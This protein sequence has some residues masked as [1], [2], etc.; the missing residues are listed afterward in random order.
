MF[1]VPLLPWFCGE[2]GYGFVR[3]VYAVGGLMFN[4]SSLI[5]LVWLIVT[6]FLKQN[7]ALAFSAVALFCAVSHTSWL[8]TKYQ[9]LAAYGIATLFY[10]G[11]CVSCG[12]Q[13]HRWRALLH[14]IFACSVYMYFERKQYAGFLLVAFLCAGVLTCSRAMRAVDR[15]LEGFGVW[16]ILFA[17]SVLDPNMHFGEVV[18][19]DKGALNACR[20]VLALNTWCVCIGVCIMLCVKRL[21]GLLEPEDVCGG[22]MLWAASCLS[23]GAFMA[24]LL[25][26]VCAYKPV[27]L[28]SSVP[29]AYR[30][31]IG[32]AVAFIIFMPKTAAPLPPF[33]ATY[34]AACV[35]PAALAYALSLY[36]KKQNGFPNLSPALR[37][38]VGLLGYLGAYHWGL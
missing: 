22:F 24:A 36:C 23:H 16:L 38:C 4:I 1:F 12:W 33:S 17:F 11:A 19:L 18:V 35:A 5:L 15:D 10:V 13:T 14:S 7:R 28:V 21:Y 6:M 32:G 34:M 25:F 9:F 20:S 37:L 8:S 31:M 30:L 2:Y 26:W 29:W 3:R 27:S